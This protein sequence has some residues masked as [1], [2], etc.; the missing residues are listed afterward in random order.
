MSLA[1]DQ[2]LYEKKNITAYVSSLRSSVVWKKN[3]ITYVSSL[4][5]NKSHYMKKQYMIILKLRKS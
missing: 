1:S 2:V 3:I 5:K 4:S